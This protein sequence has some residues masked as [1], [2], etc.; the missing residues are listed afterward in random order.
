MKIQARNENGVWLLHLKGRL[1]APW[2]GAF[3]RSVA[4][5]LNHPAP[6]LI[7]DLRELEYIDSTGLGA[8][9]SILRKVEFKGGGLRLQNLNSE[10]ESLFA[11]RLHKLLPSR[12][13]LTM[14][15]TA[16]RSRRGLLPYGSPRKIPGLHPQRMAGDETEARS[17]DRGLHPARSS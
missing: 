5:Y 13:V 8:L 4:S 16:M 17:D 12:E 6:Q 7:L 15:R 3:K 2:V 14:P 10:I 9:L 11:T 1:D